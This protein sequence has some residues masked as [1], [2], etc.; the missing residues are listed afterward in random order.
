MAQATRSDSVSKSQSAHSSLT[1]ITYG[2]PV[3]AWGEPTEHGQSTVKW[4][5]RLHLYGARVNFRGRVY[6]GFGETEGLAV[7]SA[8]KV[9]AEMVGVMHAE[10]VTEFYGDADCETVAGFYEVR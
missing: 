7:S 3:A 5:D 1:N 2:R 8:L 4:S 9:A 6:S 10:A